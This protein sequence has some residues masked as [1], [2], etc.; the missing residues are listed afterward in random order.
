MDNHNEEAAGTVS[1]ARRR[2]ENK[3]QAPFSN[4][5]LTPYR[6]FENEQFRGGLAEVYLFILADMRSTP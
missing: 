2:K 3:L 1:A 6:P 4:P 5:I